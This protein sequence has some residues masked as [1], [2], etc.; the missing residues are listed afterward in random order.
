MLRGT[1]LVF[2]GDGRRKLTLADQDVGIVREMG[3]LIIGWNW[4]DACRKILLEVSYIT[5]PQ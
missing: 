2:K 4:N 3:T 1:Y 5:V